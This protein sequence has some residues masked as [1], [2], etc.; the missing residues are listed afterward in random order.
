MARPLGRVSTQEN[1]PY[2][3][4]GTAPQES[5]RTLLPKRATKYCAQHPLWA[6]LFF[7]G[8]SG[9][10]GERALSTVLLS[11][12]GEGVPELASLPVYTA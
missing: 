4:Q 3:K 9:E 6:Q 7:Q 10:T 12:A 2:K 1:V 5:V 11:L 8:N